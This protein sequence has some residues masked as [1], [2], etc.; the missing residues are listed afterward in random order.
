MG[1]IKLL[2]LALI[3]VF[4]IT[5][6]CKERLFNN[7][8]DPD[9]NDRGYEIESTLNIE[10][11][12]I[13]GD[14]SFSGDSLWLVN[15]NSTL[16]SINYNSGNIIRSLEHSYGDINGVSYDGSNLWIVLNEG[17]EVNKISIISGE[18]IRSLKISNGDYASMDF[19]GS[20]LYLADRKSNS[21]ILFDSQSGKKTGT[22][23]V[24][25]FS[26]D[27]F[28]YDGEFFWII[29]ISTQRIYQIDS[30]GNI[31]NSFKTPSENPSSLAC[32]NEIVWMGDANGKI[33]KLRFR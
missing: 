21:I 15:G 33:Y 18:I 6:G 1:K 5:S 16:Y 7:P 27:G 26:I 23:R 3:I 2:Y 29:E 9:K 19:N 14:L 32:S 25:V 20:T 11:G 4:S 10:N 24:P 8:Y 22:V 13:P 30:S 31:V 17:S 12:L 28:C